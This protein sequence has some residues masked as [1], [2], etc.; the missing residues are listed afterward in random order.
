MGIFFSCLTL[1]TDFCH[2]KGQGT[3][4]IWNLEALTTN[5]YVTKSLTCWAHSSV[6]YFVKVT[7]PLT[8]SSNK[9]CCAESSWFTGRNSSATARTTR[10]FSIRFLWLS[11][12]HRILLANNMNYFC[13]NWQEHRKLQLLSLIKCSAKITFCLQFG[14]IDLPKMLHTVTLLAV[15]I[16]AGFKLAA[17]FMGLSSYL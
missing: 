11:T 3:S 10:H 4:P 2:T 1:Y 7:R 5:S 17:T 8:V 9:W 12:L 13:A 16:D 14:T 15:T 6:R